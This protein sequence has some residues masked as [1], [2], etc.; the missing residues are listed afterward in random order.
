MP[1]ERSPR[2]PAAWL[3]GAAVSASVLCL[4]H[5]LALPLVIALLPSVGEAIAGSATH[6]ILLAFAVPV[7]GWVLLRAGQRVPIVLGA[8]GLALMTIAVAAFEGRPAERG[9][10]VAGVILVAL[11][12]VVRWRLSRRGQFSAATGT[13]KPFARR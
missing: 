13:G 1:A 12:H 10:T 8:A 6:W 7:S 9:L 4:F 3:D 5:C 2:S 11:A